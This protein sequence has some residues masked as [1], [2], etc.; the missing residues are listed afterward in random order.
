MHHRTVIAADIAKTSFQCIR[1]RDNQPI[2][3]SKSYKRPAFEK[4]ITADKPM[5]LIMESCSGAHHWA[6]IAEQ[7][8]HDV[9]LIPPK[10]VTGFRQGHKTDTTDTFAIFDASR[11]TNLKPSVRKSLE[12]QALQ[13]L[14]SVRNGYQDRKKQLSNAI[15]GHLAEFGIVMPKGYA[16]L[17]R[18]LPDLLEDPEN[19]LPDAVR[20]ALNE[21]WLDWQKAN[22]LETKLA[23]RIKVEL[24]GIS[25]AKELLKLEG[26]GPVNAV[27]LLCALGDG[28]SFN[29]GKDAAAYIGLTPKQHSTGG[30]ETFIGIGK[31]CGHKKLRS[32]LIQGAR[33]M[34]LAVNA[35]GAVSETELWLLALVERCGENRAAVALA[36][37]NVRRAWALKTHQ[38]TCVLN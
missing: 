29:K 16:T 34:I 33:A 22:D 38:R 25:A 8:G 10:T 3:K 37:K 1:F 36:N 15:R 30:K 26:I 4:L 2:S 7:H 20:F 18:R 35:R 28:R 9:L 23:E 5:T 24:K 31:R 17:K 32:S 19:S 21:Y 6:R 11:S 14:G 13:V 27:G 12:T